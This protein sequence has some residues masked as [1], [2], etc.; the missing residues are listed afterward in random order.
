MSEEPRPEHLDLDRNRGLTVHW[1]DGRVSF[2]PVAYLRRMSPSAEMRELREQMERNPLTVLPESMAGASS[3]NLYATDAE[4][5]G[6][7]AIRIRFSDGHHTGLYSWDYLRRIDPDQP[8]E[9]S[10]KQ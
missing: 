1:D 5:V 3:E 6:N 8:S 2:Y 9:N 4:L 10:E 7:Y